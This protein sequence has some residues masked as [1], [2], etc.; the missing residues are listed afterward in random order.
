MSRNEVELCT[1]TDLDEGRR[2]IIVR[3]VGG[4]GLVR[5]LAEMGLTPGTEVKLLKKGPFGGP[6]EV[7]VRGVAL[8]LGRGVAS[9]VLVKPVKE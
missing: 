7:E 5:R 1:L 3:A 4:Y 8:A 6:I 2:G 9:K